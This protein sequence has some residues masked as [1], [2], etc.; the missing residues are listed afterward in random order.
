MYD[1]GSAHVIFMDAA[2]HLLQTLLV[3]QG[4]TVCTFLKP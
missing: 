4:K 2:A 3:T 1:L